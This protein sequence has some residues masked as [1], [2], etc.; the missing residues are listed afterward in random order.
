[1]R[2]IPASPRK[3][4]LQSILSPKMKQR[5][6]DATVRDTTSYFGEQGRALSLRSPLS[7]IGDIDANSVTGGSF[8]RGKVHSTKENIVGRNSRMGVE[9]DKESESESDQEDIVSP[10]T[11]KKKTNVIDK[12]KRKVFKKRG[13]D[14]DE[15]TTKG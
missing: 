6:P 7:R 4:P 8:S 2:L 3:T 1:M 10:T 14:K 5:P 15:T 11:E 12:M 9:V 13:K